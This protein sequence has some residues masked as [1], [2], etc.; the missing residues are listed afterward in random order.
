[1]SLYESVF[2]TSGSSYDGSDSSRT[3][4][5]LHGNYH[6]FDVTWAVFGEHTLAACL[7]H[8]A[9]NL[10]IEVLIKFPFLDN[11]TTSTGF[12]RSFDCGESKHGS[13]MALVGSRLK[14][15]ESGM[16]WIDIV[17]SALVRAAYASQLEQDVDRS[18]LMLRTHDIVAQIRESIISKTRRSIITSTWSS[19]LEA[20]CYEF[21]HPKKLRKY[22]ELFWT[23][24]Y[25]NWP[26][27]HQPTFDVCAKS[28][29]RLA[30]MTIVGACLSSDDRDRA[31]AQLW[32]DPIEEIVFDDDTFSIQDPSLAWQ[33]SGNM[34][35]CDRQL[36][37]LQAAYC[38]CL[39]QTWEG[40][41]ASRKRIIRH[42]FSSLVFLAR[43]IGFTSASL[44]TVD[45]SNLSSFN[46]VEYI[47]RESLIRIF[48][49]I[50]NLDS[51]FAQFYRHS[52]RMSISEMEVDLAAPD[53][54]FQA[55]SAEECFVALKIWRNSFHSPAD[56][57]TVSS[58]VRALCDPGTNTSA[59]YRQAFAHLS[60][61][62]MFT[63]ISAL[64]AETHRL[65]T[66]I[67]RSFNNNETSALST[68]LHQW[69]EFWP[70]PIRDAELAGLDHGT[71]KT[72]GF[73][74]HAPEYWLL[75]H[76]IL[77]NRIKRDKINDVPAV[78]RCADGE[79]TH[80]RALIT[81]FQ[82]LDPGD[83]G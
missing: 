31:L 64:Y 52:P 37:L 48:M 67:I 25:P 73:I 58:T 76:L 49:Y 22:L 46:W 83:I 30:A 72:I 7:S 23:H 70:S 55:T 69:K 54:C 2:T 13:S 9:T 14:N 62:N 44:R 34:E 35:L 21:F 75:T 47:Q 68:A 71:S 39:Y 82:R 24:W 8:R 19:S 77:Q 50:F 78:M 81:N 40:G 5:V 28:S 60:V 4:M 20:M 17:E 18:H 33:S 56:N 45:T 3:S 1:M 65:E 29:G 16:N 12:V 11:F 74:R 53:V 36:D 41:K 27:V 6:D 63:V 66:S 79:M 15:L 57:L 51:A 59:E 32:F 26:T 10:N 80:T 38:I 43:D 61:L 42:R